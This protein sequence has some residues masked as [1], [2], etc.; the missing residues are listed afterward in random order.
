M[1]VFRMKKSMEKMIFKG[2]PTS[3]FQDFKSLYLG[4]GIRLRTQ[5]SS[6]GVILTFYKRV[7]NFTVFIKFQIIFEIALNLVIEVYAI[8]KKL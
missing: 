2:C 4:S 5:N 6:V 1:P 8:P 3:K 7:K